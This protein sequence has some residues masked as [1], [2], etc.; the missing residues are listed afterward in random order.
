MRQNDSLADDVCSDHARVDHAVVRPVASDR[1]NTAPGAGA[2]VQL[3]LI[4]LPPI[5]PPA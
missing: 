5:T 4:L 3:V 1:V 2:V